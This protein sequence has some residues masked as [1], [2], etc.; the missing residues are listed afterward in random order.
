MTSDV[1]LDFIFVTVFGTKNVIFG[2][3]VTNITCN[4]LIVKSTFRVKKSPWKV[5]VLLHREII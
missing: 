4:L 1:V 2:T 3:I 5:Q